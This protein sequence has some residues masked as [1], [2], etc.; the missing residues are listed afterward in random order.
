M[1]LFL[2]NQGEPTMLYAL[3]PSYRRRALVQVEAL[4]AQAERDLTRH[5]AARTGKAKTEGRLQPERR[6]LA[7]LHRSRQFLL[8]DEFSRI[9]AGRH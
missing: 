5:D 6:R 1:A 8:S 2:E 7:L 3:P 9:K 4:I